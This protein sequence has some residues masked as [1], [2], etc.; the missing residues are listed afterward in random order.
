MLAKTATLHLQQL[1]Q[2]HSLTALSYL[3]LFKMFHLNYSAVGKKVFLRPR[4]HWYNDDSKVRGCQNGSCIQCYGEKLILELSTCFANYSVLWASLL[5][6]FLALVC[7]SSLLFWKWGGLASYPRSLQITIS[8][9]VLWMAKGINQDKIISCIPC[10]YVKL[11]S[12]NVSICLCD[13]TSTNWLWKC[14]VQMN[15]ARILFWWYL[16][17]DQSCLWQK[18]LG[19]FHFCPWA[20]TIFLI[21]ISAKSA[22]PFELEIGWYFSK[23]KLRCFFAFKWTESFWN[24]HARFFVL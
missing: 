7:L 5:F 3:K 24:F 10:Q 23:K 18:Y 22:H 14:H 13:S 6:F 12:L 16:S 21:R 15:K 17:L 1:L 20:L 9:E 2:I 4:I 11:S 8:W 19:W